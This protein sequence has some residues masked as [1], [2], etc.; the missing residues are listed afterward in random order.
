[1]LKREYIQRKTIT[2]RKLKD[3][4]IDGMAKCIKATSRIDGNLDE[5]V[6]DFDK[7]L[8]NTL[9]IHVPL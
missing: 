8:R 3:I 5:R 1:M 7:A 6:M 9:N 2:Y 4:D